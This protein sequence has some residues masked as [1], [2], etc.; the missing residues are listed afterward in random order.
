MC[1][2]L[3]PLNFLVDADACHLGAKRYLYFIFSAPTPL[4]QKTFPRYWFNYILAFKSN[5]DHIVKFLL[6]VTPVIVRSNKVRFRNALDKAIS[7]SK[8]ANI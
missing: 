6:S 1:M 5:A 2:T 3:L 4:V 8:Y 7:K